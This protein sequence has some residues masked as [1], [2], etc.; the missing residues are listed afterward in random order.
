MIL[1]TVCKYS[2]ML[3]TVPAGPGNSW[4]FGGPFSR[5]GK[6]WKMMIMSWNFYNC[7]EKFCSCKLK[8]EVVL[9]RLL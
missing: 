7:T 9:D 4:N 3:S 8:N 1:L 2:A 5:P 6:S